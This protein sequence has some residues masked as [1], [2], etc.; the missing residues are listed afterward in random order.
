MTQIYKLLKSSKGL[1]CDDCSGSGIYL[2]TNPSLGRHQ[3]SEH[4][5]Q[6]SQ[7]FLVL[8]LQHIMERDRRQTDIQTAWREISLEDCYQ[9]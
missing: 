1:A 5:S 2:E 6:A 8:V 4:D 7:T 9:Y 3:A